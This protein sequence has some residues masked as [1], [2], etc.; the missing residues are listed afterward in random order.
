MFTNLLRNMLS[1]INVTDC[2]NVDGNKLGNTNVNKI[3]DILD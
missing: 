2:A 1:G 3:E